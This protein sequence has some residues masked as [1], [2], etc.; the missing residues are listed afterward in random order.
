MKLYRNADNDERGEPQLDLVL[1][2][3]S[4][5]ELKALGSRFCQDGG[6]NAAVWASSSELRHELSDNGRIYYVIRP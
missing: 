5:E 3:D 6:I 2:S 1:R 4:V